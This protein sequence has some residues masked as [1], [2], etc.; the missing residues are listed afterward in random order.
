M[1][2][3][4]QTGRTFT[5]TVTAGNLARFR[6]AVRA[7]G[8]SIIVSSPVREGYAVTVFVPNAR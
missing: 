6:R 2:T 8:G 5:E 1:T 3:P 7:M 4:T